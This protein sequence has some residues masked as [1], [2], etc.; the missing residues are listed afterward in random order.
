MDLQTPAMKPLQILIICCVIV[1]AFFLRTMVFD[2]FRSSQFRVEITGPVI[3]LE[4]PY[5]IDNG[6]NRILDTINQGDTVKVTKT[7]TSK[8][9]VALKVKLKNGKSGYIIK[10]D[11]FTVR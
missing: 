11:N 8:E 1:A 3:L 2:W 4:A 6:K 10:G 7:I 5:P 9:Y